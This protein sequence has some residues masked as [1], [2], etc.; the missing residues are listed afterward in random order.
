MGQK[1]AKRKTLI[2]SAY[3]SS[4]KSVTLYNIT[5]VCVVKYTP[6]SL[7]LYDAY[8]YTPPKKHLSIKPLYRRQYLTQN[9]FNKILWLTFF[10]FFFFFYGIRLKYFKIL[11]HITYYKIPHTNFRDLGYPLKLL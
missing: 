3:Q 9:Q 4:F 8:S 6:H 2:L 1:L 5:C 11:L 10:F 7:P